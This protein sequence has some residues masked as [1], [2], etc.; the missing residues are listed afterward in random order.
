MENIIIF[1]KYVS[2]MLREFM[3]QRLQLNINWSP[4]S[5][6]IFTCEEMNFHERTCTVKSGSK[7]IPLEL[8]LRCT[9]VYSLYLLS[10]F[11]IL[12]VCAVY[13]HIRSL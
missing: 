1:K 10:Q 2:D 4:A 3:I 8:G 7:C 9:V 5:C 11:A 12:H 6:K 13:T